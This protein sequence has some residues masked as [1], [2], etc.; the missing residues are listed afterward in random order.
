[1]AAYIPITMESAG[2]IS[3][4]SLAVAVYKIT[5]GDSRKDERLVKVVWKE[6]LVGTV[7]G[8][9][10]GLTLGLVGAICYGNSLLRIII[11]IY[12]WLNLSISTVGGAVI[13]ILINKLKIDPAVASVPFITAIND[14]FGSMIY[15]SIAT[16]LLHLL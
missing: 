14:P 7:L 8:V 13:P 12:L 11:G 4:Q 3:T 16:Q 2:K 9:A 15:F 6:F 1:M 5:V 10:A